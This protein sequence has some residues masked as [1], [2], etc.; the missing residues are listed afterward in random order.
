MQVET[1]ADVLEWTRSVHAN[2]ATCLAHCSAGCKRE[3]VK[4]LLDYLAEHEHALERV[5]LLSQQDASR[6]AL[7][8]WCYDYFDKAPVK[9]HEQ[10]Q[11]DFRD[12]DTDDIIA[13]VLAMHEKII[14]LY[15]YLASQAQ[16]PSARNLLESLLA[17]EEHEA[18]RLAR[19]TGSLADL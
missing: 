10:C 11:D 14:A 15:R 6:Q 19:D 9:P 12:K 8:T 7:N 4:M 3:K 13:N 16:V 17:L 2:M 5:L 18:M 1:M